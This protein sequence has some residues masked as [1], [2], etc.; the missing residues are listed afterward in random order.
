MKLSI[1]ALPLAFA[2]LAMSTPLA[3][4]QGDPVKSHNNA[5]GCGPDFEGNCSG[6]TP[7][8]DSPPVCS[9]HKVFGV[10]FNLASRVFDYIATGWQ[11][12]Y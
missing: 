8:N 1:F 7:H 5:G 9:C 12:A 2:T 6:S 4:P 3:K 11:L 10:S